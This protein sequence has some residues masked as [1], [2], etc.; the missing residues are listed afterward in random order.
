MSLQCPGDK[1]EVIPSSC[2]LCLVFSSSYSLVYGVFDN[3]LFYLY[4]CGCY[5]L[6][7]LWSPTGFLPVAR[8]HGTF[9]HLVDPPRQTR[10]QSAPPKR[11][12]AE[13][14]RKSSNSQGFWPVF[15]PGF[16]RKTPDLLLSTG[17][18]AN[19]FFFLPWRDLWHRLVSWGH[20]CELPTAAPDAPRTPPI[21]ISCCERRRIP[22]RGTV[23]LGERG[24]GG[25]NLR[26]LST[27]KSLY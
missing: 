26:Y 5:L 17:V 11:R 1:Q 8:C 27:F 10:S 12:G 4:R 19:V 16:L 15:L 13:T 23:S 9:L 21:R 24:F 18:Y 2:L 20:S 25:Q 3:I 6:V 22:I 7:V 14:W